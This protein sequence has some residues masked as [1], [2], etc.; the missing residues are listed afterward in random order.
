MADRFQLSIADLTIGFVSAYPRLAAEA[1]GKFF[2]PFRSKKHVDLRM[3]VECG[4]LPRVRPE[5]RLFDAVSPHRWRLA[6][7][8]GHYVFEVFDT[9]SPH[10][11]FQV[12]RVDPAWS[13]VEV[14]TRPVGSV[15]GKPAWS[16]ARLMQPLGQLLLIQ[17]LSQGRGVLL[18]GLGVIDRGKGLL[19]VGRSGAGKSTLAN[20]YAETA[21]DATVLNDEHIAVVKRGEKFWVFSTPWP[22]AHF[23]VCA[24]GAP[25]HR[26][27]VLEHDRTNQRLTEHPARL[28]AL[29]AQQMF[30]PFW[31]REALA[32][33][34]RLAEE[35][36][37]AIPTGRLGFVNDARI[38]DF[39]RE[40]A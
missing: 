31:S 21:T 7:E 39:L 27:Y 16:L 5:A 23:Q 3:T 6:R 17:H 11:R 40:E 15:R 30:L 29:L 26:I 34:L 25:I 1:P 33:A 18:H 20:L 22:G 35:L 9:R 32:W 24:G 4:N 2:A 36:V 28:C 14:H 38:I 12:A 13:A 19:F 8:D 37:Q 10:A